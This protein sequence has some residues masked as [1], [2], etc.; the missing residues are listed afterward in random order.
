M[1]SAYIRLLNDLCVRLGFCGS[2]SDDEPLDVSML[3]PD[4]GPVSAD[5]F[6]DAVLRA[7]GFD[8]TQAAT[9]EHRRAIRETFV[10]HLGSSQ[11]DA[12]LLR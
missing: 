1:S 3:L 5:E 4:R 7:E 8:A 11:V 12:T 6:V 2:I 9:S 10:R